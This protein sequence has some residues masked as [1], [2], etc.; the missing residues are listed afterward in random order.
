[1][2]NTDRNAC[3]HAIIRRKLDLPDDTPIPE[4]GETWYAFRKA[5]IIRSWPYDDGMGGIRVL[6]C[7][8]ESV[9]VHSHILI[10][11]LTPEPPISPLH[12]KIADLI[13]ADL[14]IPSDQRIPIPGEQGWRIGNLECIIRSWPYVYI[15]A[16]NSRPYV[17]T[18]YGTHLLSSLTPPKS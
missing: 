4:P 10:G 17:L 7:K 11:D 15:G 6:V 18:S 9:D 8:P 12:K 13:R 14:G 1:M 5:Y 2:C 16:S 3:F